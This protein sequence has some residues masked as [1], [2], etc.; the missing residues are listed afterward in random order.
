MLT[1]EAR[2]D[3]HVV[4]LKAVPREQRAL[5]SDAASVTRPVSK[6][7]VITDHVPNQNYIHTTGT[8]ASD[9]PSTLMPAAASDSSERSMHTCCSFCRMKI[10]QLLILGD[11]T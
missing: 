5:G 11:T 2:I 3:S 1:A 10:M 4:A 8:F 9:L 7:A 6:A